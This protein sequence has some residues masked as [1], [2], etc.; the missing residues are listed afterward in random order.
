VLLL[1][2]S[3]S[4]YRY[5]PDEKRLCVWQSVSP[6][7][8]T[9]PGEVVDLDLASTSPKTF[10]LPT[11][12]KLRRLQATAP[13]FPQLNRALVPKLSQLSL[14]NAGKPL[15]A[16]IFE[17]DGLKFLN[18]ANNVASPAIK[19]LV[20]LKTLWIKG[21]AVFDMPTSVSGCPIE[22]LYCSNGIAHVAEPLPRWVAELPLKN[23]RLT[24]SSFADF[25]SLRSI[26]TLERIDAGAGMTRVLTFPD[27]SRLRRLKHLVVS[28]DS[29]QSQSVSK[30][31]MFSQVLSG[32]ASLES[33]E[34]LDVSNW[35]PKTKADV[36]HWIGSKRTIPNF[37]HRLTTLRRLE[38]SAMGLETLPPGLDKLSKLR[39]LNLFRNKL[40]RHE[41]E[42]LASALTKCEIRSDF[43]TFGPSYKPSTDSNQWWQPPEL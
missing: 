41:V 29:V 19:N 43:G 10:V 17:L 31:T 22:T 26:G 32:I 15:A 14:G 30:Y 39:S 37:F 36:L 20:R 28:G 9:D 2:V 23:V 8:D 1:G 11:M 34:F 12:P 24:V 25:D 21:Q 18:L 38:M 40:P 5:F 4:A 3:N 33:L 6:F 16:N 42:Q 27:L 7:K 13:W 35:R